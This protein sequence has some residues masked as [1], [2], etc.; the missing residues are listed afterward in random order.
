MSPQDPFC[1]TCIGT[2]QVLTILDKA[3]NTAIEITLRGGF[4]MS[5]SIST[6]MIWKGIHLFFPEIQQNLS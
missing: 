4:G 5:Y 3:S 1:S 2:H 6:Q